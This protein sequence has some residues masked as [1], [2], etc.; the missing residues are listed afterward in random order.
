MGRNIFLFCMLIGA[1]CTAQ[2]SVLQYMQLQKCYADFPENDAR[3]LPAVQK[4]IRLGK[5]NQNFRHL[6]Y[7]YEDA[8]YYS[9]DR[10]QKLL[11][12][13]SIIQAA[14]KTGDTAMIS[15]AYLAKGIVFYFNYR[16]Y[17]QA[18]DQYLEAA[19]FADET[20]EDYLIFKIKYNIGVVKSYLGYHEEAIA[21][22]RECSHFFADQMKNSKHPT[23]TFNNTRGYLNSLHQLSISYRHRKQWKQADSLLMISAA[24]LNQP[25]FRQENAYFLK[26]KGIG[27]ARKKLYTKS[28]DT[29]LAAAEILKEKEEEGYLTVVFYSIATDYLLLN[30]QGLATNYLLKVDSLFR[31][32][33]TVLPETRAAYELL[34]KSTDYRKNP[35]Q[36]SYYITQLLKADQQLNHDVPY[37]SS[38]IHR[39]YDTKKLW[40]E[41]NKLM[42]AKKSGDHLVVLSLVIS[43]TLVGF[44]M[45][46]RRRQKKILHAYQ[47]L[48]VTLNTPPLTSAITE[49][50]RR[51]NK[52]PWYEPHTAENIL[53]KL[54]VFEEQEGFIN[55][56]LTIINLAAALQV[57][58][59]N[60][61]YVINEHL[62][63]NFTTYLNTLRIR[64]ITEK[65]NNDRE[66][67]KLK[68]PELAR[69]CGIKSRQHFSRLFYEH[70]KIRPSDFIEL[71]IKQLKS[72]N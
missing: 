33:R 50:I 57:T 36:A 10:R 46:S 69:K 30:K 1:V 8:A 67:L 24:Y 23:L 43:L 32:N 2:E 71:R 49:E 31:K 19:A 14:K 18:L 39:E 9:K 66:F 52:K 60:L 40:A 44:L 3:A 56:D 4:S 25:D 70:N 34:L 45:I 13:D 38:R 21:L 41:R 27:I 51:Q 15:K 5:K 65:L 59:N 54:K 22:F 12:S 55:P 7:A 11:Y 64:Y 61:S 63:M 48:Q 29:L 62:N 17:D 42:K 47:K 28:I 72:I 35:D 68:T 53:Q 58:K 16:N 6:V 20:G 37:L 26:E